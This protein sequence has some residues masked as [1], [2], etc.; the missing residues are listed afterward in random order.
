L[1]LTSSEHGGTVAPS[2]VRLRRMAADPYCNRFKESKMPQS[3]RS[4]LLRAT[5]LGIL[6]LASL[7]EPGPLRAGVQAACAVCTGTGE[8]PASHLW[9]YDS[10]C[11]AHCGPFSY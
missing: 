4:L 2:I 10:A 6:S 11:Q 7:V 1:L 3:F 8:C 5:C 9:Y